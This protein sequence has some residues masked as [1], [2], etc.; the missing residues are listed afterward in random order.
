MS[1]AFDTVSKESLSIHDNEFLYIKTF[2]KKF[3]DTV[4]VEMH[5]VRFASG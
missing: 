4:L 1:I 5:V 2:K 3:R